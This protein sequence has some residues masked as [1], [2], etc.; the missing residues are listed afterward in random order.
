[1]GGGFTVENETE[2]VDPPTRVS[3]SAGIWSQ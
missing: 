3:I 2:K 1:M